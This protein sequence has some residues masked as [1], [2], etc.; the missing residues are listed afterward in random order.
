MVLR[1]SVVVV[2]V[3]GMT[4][5]V[6]IANSPMVARQLKIV[7]AGHT[8]CLPDENELSNINAS[9]DGSGTWNVAILN[10]IAAPLWP[11]KG[12]ALPLPRPTLA[13]AVHGRCYPY[14]AAMLT[15]REAVDRA[16]V[17]SGATTRSEA[18]A[19]P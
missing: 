5:C 11:S 18:D 12:G 13:T 14:R 8:G 19:A 6:A 9:A 1:A 16:Q 7:S 17:I 3:F 10:R 4:G 15:H 2:V